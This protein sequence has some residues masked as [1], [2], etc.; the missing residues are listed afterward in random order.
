M[1]KLLYTFLAVSIIF[2]ACKKEEEEPNNNGNNNG[3]NNTHTYVPNTNFELKLISLG[4]DD[5]LDDYVLTTNIN[6]LE[7][8]DLQSGD[9]KNVSNISNIT[10]IEDFVAL[11]E[12]WC[13]GI[14]LKSLD[15]STNL[16]LTTLM[17]CC[18]ELTSLDVSNNTALIALNCGNDQLISLDVRNGN[19][20][21]FIEFDSNTELDNTPLTCINVDDAAWSTANWLDINDES[22]FSEDCSVK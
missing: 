8:L 5:V 14:Q 12:L 10:G 9:G 21:N 7:I 4:L 3:S 22:F 13:G 20:S 2:S 18:N 19:N 1:K 16:L 11:K 15:V 6:D 17:C